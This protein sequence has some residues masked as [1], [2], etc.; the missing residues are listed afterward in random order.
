[1]QALSL[2]IWESREWGED[3]RPALN[4]FADA[5]GKECHIAATLVLDSGHMLFCELPAPASVLAAMRKRNDRQIM[6]LE[7]I[8]I[9]LGICS[10][11]EH[12]RG[13]KVRIWSDN[14]GAESSVRRGSSKRFDHCALSHA[15]WVKVL[16][17]ASARA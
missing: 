17:R 2:E 11:S 15:I 10:F 12:L 8:S 16:A 4:L 5:A 3:S 7:I 1:M 6:G 13:R 9:A 14:T